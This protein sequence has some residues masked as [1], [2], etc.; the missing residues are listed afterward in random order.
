M[1]FHFMCWFI[2]D[3]GLHNIYRL[4][5]QKETLIR[6]Q[7]ND[8]GSCDFRN[9]LGLEFGSEI[10]IYFSSITHAISFY[11]FI[12]S[13]TQ[14]YI[15]FTGSN[16]SKKLRID[17]KSNDI[18]ICDFSVELGIEFGNEISIYFSSITYQFYFMWWIYPRLMTH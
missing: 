12:L 17:F 18:G 2:L 14:D 1:H 4:K 16:F 3:S 5:F 6:L 8:I 11:V 10:S 9:E 7:S 15:I 13:S